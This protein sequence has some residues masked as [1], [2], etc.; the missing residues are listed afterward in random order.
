MSFLIGKE[1]CCLLFVTY[2]SFTMNQAGMNP[3]LSAAISIS[4]VA[5]I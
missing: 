4:V 3:M 2:L 1:G 5:K